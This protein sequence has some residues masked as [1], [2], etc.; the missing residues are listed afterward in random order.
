MSWVK[1]HLK[2]LRDKEFKDWWKARAELR[3][4]LVGPHAVAG[5]PFSFHKRGSL[6]RLI[7]ARS[8]HGDFADYHKRFRYHNSNNYYSCGKKKF[9]RHIFYCKKLRKYRLLPG[10]ILEA[11]I[12]QFLG[13][14]REKWLRFMEKSRFYTKIYL[15]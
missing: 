10:Y 7:T 11:T 2:A 8:G 9:T 12:L 13:E 3:Y 1:R 6:H 4:R 14:D 5:R 15:R